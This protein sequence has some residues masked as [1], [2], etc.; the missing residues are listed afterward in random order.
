MNAQNIRLL[1]EFLGEKKDTPTKSSLDPDGMAQ[2]NY[3]ATHRPIEGGGI[4]SFRTGG[5]G[6]Y[7]NPFRRDVGE[8]L[9]DVRLGYVSSEKART[10]YGVMLKP[11][12]KTVDIKETMKLRAASTDSK[13]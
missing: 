3:K 13:M 2:K 6:G 1:G 9:D 11:D 5:G 4:I 8:V 7:G 10:D 12:G